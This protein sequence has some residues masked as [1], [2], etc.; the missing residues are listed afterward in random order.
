MEARHQRN[1]RIFGCQTPRPYKPLQMP[2]YLARANCLEHKEADVLSEGSAARRLWRQEPN[3][4]VDSVAISMFRVPVSLEKHLVSNEQKNAT[5]QSSFCLIPF[6]LLESLC[7][8]PIKT[9]EK[10]KEEKRKKRKRER[11]KT[12]PT[13]HFSSFSF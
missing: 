3:P 11:K 6:C 4:H 5:M 13:K 2:Y 8:M 7:C 9:R 12:K 1:R 10:K